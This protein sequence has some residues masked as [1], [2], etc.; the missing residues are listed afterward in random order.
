MALGLR[1]RK[2]LKANCK[3]LNS[4]YRKRKKQSVAD[5]L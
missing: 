2:K 5:G 1:L 4:G 3:D